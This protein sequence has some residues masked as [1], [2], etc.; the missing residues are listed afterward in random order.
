MIFGVHIFWDDEICASIFH[1]HHVV[2]MNTGLILFENG[3]ELVVVVMV[4]PDSCS[5]VSACGP[6]EPHVAS[7][8][9]GDPL[10]EV[11]HLVVY[12]I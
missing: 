6:S 1:L 11:V 7:W 5:E 3:L 4:R 2:G 10:S 12:Y 9:L 8:V